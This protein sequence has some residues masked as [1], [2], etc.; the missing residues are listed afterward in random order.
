MSRVEINDGIAQGSCELGRAQAVTMVCAVVH[1][2]AIVDDG[3]E[4]DHLEIGA[5]LVRTVETPVAPRPAVEFAV[6]ATT[7][8][9]A[10]RL[11]ARPPALVERVGD[12]ALIAAL[13]AI[14]RPTGLVRRGDRVWLTNDVLGME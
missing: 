4:L 3:E 10:E 12:E 11:A 5:G 9:L 13:A 6:V 7:S 14:D 2:A 8:G 1:A